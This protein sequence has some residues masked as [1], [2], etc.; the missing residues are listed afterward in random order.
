LGESVGSVEHAGAA[1]AVVGVVGCAAVVVVWVAAG[2]VAGFLGVV[3]AV[4]LDA[5]TV[6]RARAARVRRF[7]I[8]VGL[9]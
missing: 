7:E 4:W 2:A 9:V 5:V 3:V 8:I 6:T 1:A